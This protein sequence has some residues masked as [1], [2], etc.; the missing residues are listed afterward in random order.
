[1]GELLELFEIYASSEAERRERERKESRDFFVAGTALVGQ[2]AL[3]LIGGAVGKGVRAV[4]GRTI[5]EASASRALST[6]EKL[7]KASK[8]LGLES[9]VHTIQSEVL[10]EYAMHTTDALQ[11]Q[12]LVTEMKDV[13]A[14]TIRKSSVLSEGHAITVAGKKF[15]LKIDAS[16]SALYETLGEEI[17][18][19]YHKTAEGLYDKVYET[20]G[21]TKQIS[22]KDRALFTTKLNK[23]S[24]LAG[25]VDLR[26]V[27][28]NAVATLAQTD[29]YKELIKS[30]Q[31][32]RAI[33]SN[34][35]GSGKYSAELDKMTKEIRSEVLYKVHPNI[36][37]ELQ[38]ADEFYAR[39]SILKD[40]VRRTSST[41][42][43]VE[44]LNT[45]VS[46]REE[47]YKA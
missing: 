2:G 21:P 24:L 45:D 37:G 17:P 16:S 40:I 34:A 1:M 5:Q 36:K 47:F 32:L 29:T 18:D 41:K 23:L 46:Y 14:E 7:I 22:E 35:R 3:P 31:T 20:I 38:K 44:K 8:N 10:S 19:I 6:T 11:T 27:Q 25:G 42:Q 33:A 39:G 4:F 28:K 13:G 26:E 15:D 9:G 12:E 30:T 43:L